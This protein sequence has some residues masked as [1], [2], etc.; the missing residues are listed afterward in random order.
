MDVL[1]LSAR[2][3][4][5]LE[6]QLG[7][8]TSARV[9]RRTL[10]VL[11]LNRGESVEDVA[12]TLGI[13]RQ[14]VYNWLARY[15][16]EEDPAVLAEGTHPGRPTVWTDHL[17]HRLRNLLR[18]SPDDHG[19][20]ATNWTVPLLREE[21]SHVGLHVCSDTIR[22]ELAR[23]GYV[24]K[25]SRY[26]LLPDPEQEKKTSNSPQNQAFAVAECGLGGG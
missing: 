12:D 13:S 14:T 19:Y 11:E 3:R 17:R 1:N 23:L 22:S 6:R 21:L 26:V 8:T 25:R 24:W 9:F 4:R 20:F 7:E 16:A 10:A 5:Q 18:R 15:E 2:Q